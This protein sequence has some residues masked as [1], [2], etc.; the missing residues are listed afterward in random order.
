MF[1]NNLRVLI[2]AEH[3]SSKFGGEAALPLH[4]FRILRKRGIETWLV[5]HERTREE[6]TA[7]FPSDLDRIH[8]ISDTV[9]HRLIWQVA[10]HLPQRL[11]YF[12]AGF[13][14]RL[15]TQLEQR[16]VIKQM[17]QE[18]NITLIHQP[19]PVSPK[20]P[21][22]IYGMGVPVVIG[23]MNGGMNY[24]PAFRQMQSRFVDFSLKL[25]RL[26]AYALNVLM[27]G[28][29]KAAALLVANQ[30]TKEALPS[31][32]RGQVIDLVENGVD[33]SVW[34]GEHFVT[35]ERL[36]IDPL[37][38]QSTPETTRF[39]FVGRLVDWKGV[40]L[41]LEAFNQ[42]SDHIPV[43]L[44]IIGDGVERAALESRVQTLNLMERS[45]KSVRFW[46]WM[47]QADCAQHLATCD[48]LVLPSLMECGGAAVLEAM[49][50]GLPVIA[51]NWGGPADYLNDSCGV[52]VEPTS[53]QGFIEGL[54]E[55]MM[56]LAIAPELRRAMGAAGQQRVAEQFDWEVKVD[57]MIGVYQDVLKTAS[58]TTYWRLVPNGAADGVTS[59]GL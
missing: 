9:W 19:M 45:G 39:V 16:R 54:A 57:H 14:L 21:S 24:P 38:T 3:A 34:K 58:K 5:V 36:P 25:G 32:V 31:G 33:R 51:T 59:L 12:T 2:A 44:D 47:A 7:T 11:S 23:P 56:K 22:T 10:K 43:S 46:G 55:A 1:A 35:S 6:L 27:P 52:L 50:M 4:Y 8:F 40:D 48:V 20:E 18:H 17:V 53:R 37:V 13:I 41:L 29:L 49:A 26:F 30:R 42:I 15:M 28:K